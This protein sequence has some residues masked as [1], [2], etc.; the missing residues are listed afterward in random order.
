MV[1]RSPQESRSRARSQELIQLL[2]P[3]YNE[4][5]NVAHLYATLEKESIEFDTLTFVYDSSPGSDRYANV[6]T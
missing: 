6:L 5:E 2:A 1:S 4:G 3:V